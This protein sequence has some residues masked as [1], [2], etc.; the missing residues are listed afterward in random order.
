MC[1]RDSLSLGN[2]VYPLEALATGGV[3]MLSTEPVEAGF[4]VLE[5]LIDRLEKLID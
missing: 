4:K 2:S 3:D 1:I 5:A